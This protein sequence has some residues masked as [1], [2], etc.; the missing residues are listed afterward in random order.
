MIRLIADQ[1]RQ[2]VRNVTEIARQRC[3]LCDH[4]VPSGVDKCPLCGT[5]VRQAGP[6]E[7][8]AA[9]P[10]KTDSIYEVPKSILAPSLPKIV[11]TCPLCS[12]PVDD[13]HDKCPRCG[14]PIKLV[15]A[16]Q[17]EGLKCPKCGGPKPATA[18][19]CAMCSAPVAVKTPPPEVPAVQPAVVAKPEAPLPPPIV[20]EPPPKIP[21]TIEVPERGLT[22]G[23]GVTSSPS[24]TYG[25]GAI[26][27]TGVIDAAG[28][29]NG[30]GVSMPRSARAVPKAS[31]LRR[32][33]FLTIF[34]AILIVIPIF[35]FMAFY[36]PPVPTI[37]GDFDEWSKAEMFGMYVP[38][39][40]SSIAVE[41]WSVKNYDGA[42]FMY[43]NVEGVLMSTA[44]VDSFHLFV[45]TDRDSDTGYSVSGMGADY[46]LVLD[47]WDQEVKTASVMRYDSTT[48][49]FDWNEWASYGSLTYSVDD[50]ELEASAG[51]PVALGENARYLLLTQTSSPD[52]DFSVSYP[53]PEKG[54]LLIARLEPGSSIGPTFGTVPA[55]A[56]AVLAKLVLSCEG[57]SGTVSSMVP[58]V[59]GA[60]LASSFDVTSLSPGY[61]L[62]F[63]IAVDTSDVGTTKPVSALITKDSFESTFSDIVILQDSVHSYVSTAPPS[64]RIDGA[65]G[66]WLGRLNS[67]NDSSPVGNDNIDMAATAFAGST[68]Y[69]SFYVS[70]YGEMFQGVYA[71][72]TKAQSSGG[73][74][75]GGGP[76]IHIRKSGEDVL[77]IF[78]DSDM[79]NATGL[80]VVRENKAV[81][82]EYLVDIRG[83]DGE[84]ISESLYSYDGIAWAPV[85]GDILAAKDEQRLELNVSIANI[86]GNPS[87]TTIIETTDWKDRSDWGWAGSVP[88]PW[89]VNGAGD[90]YQSDTGALWGYVGR[91]TLILGDSIV[92]IAMTS[93]DSCVVLVTNTGRTYYWEFG[94][95]TGWTEGEIYPIDIAY[96]SE[97]VSMSF[98]SKTGA[99]LLTKNGS[100]FFLMNAINPPPNKEWTFQDIVTI[101]V[102]D[103]VDLNYDGGTM[104]AMRSGANSSLSYSNNGNTFSSVTNP[105]GSTTNQ[106]EFTYIPNGPGSADDRVFVL[107]EDGAIRYSAN[108]GVTW[109]ALGDLP[110]PTGGNTSKYMGMGIDSTGYMWIVTDTGYVYRSTDST[111]YANFNYTGQ[112]PISD[113]VA[114]IPLPLIPSIPEFHL[115]LV[116]IVGMILIVLSKRTLSRRDN[117]S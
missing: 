39:S 50:G 96:Y 112:A 19:T 7:R 34:A 26:N 23:I 52:Q 65:F 62:S 114:I 1:S 4:E 60:P 28:I 64:I 107:C 57:S 71:P 102:T 73:G 8:P 94:V 51:L 109:S 68:S 104:Y 100:Y 66:D 49:L 105:T 36:Q 91:P 43:V 72:S 44:N 30:T 18:E 85:A 48:D 67:D 75:G 115:M 10:A 32:W 13:S 63:D 14:V 5:P 87:I 84:I 113:I 35:Y 15:T 22:N 95:S 97:A 29:T 77:R 16:P 70:V 54:G 38:A 117:D 103:F 61:E 86:G 76:I 40:G 116:P 41:E 80:S 45:D 25:T 101:G 17:E 89:V 74:G 58:T 92:D 99:W 69:A 42:L 27:G 9:A 31:P 56:N 20:S 3:L 111:T 108:G 47:G 93:D 90:T 81:G 78:I 83:Y 88:D 55:M 24:M 82:A 33:R 6:A 98:F 11:D 46:M 2:G 21:S 106:S 53:V 79:D 110:T 59:S 37:D 12:Y